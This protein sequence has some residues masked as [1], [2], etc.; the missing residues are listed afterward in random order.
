MKTISIIGVG[1]LAACLIHRLIYS[2]TPVKIQL[3]DKD[4]KKNN[5]SRR[6]NL[7]FSIKIDS[8]GI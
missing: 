3:Y 7:S 1:N 4:I 5:Y 8:K 6:K 2:K